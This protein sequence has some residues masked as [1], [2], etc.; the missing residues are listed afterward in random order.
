MT[1]S[2]TFSFLAEKTDEGER[3]DVVISS[4]VEDCSRNY[5]AVLVRDGMVTVCERSKKPG[6]RVRMGDEISG[7]LP[8]PV[9]VSLKPELIHIDI[10]YEDDH[11]IVLNKQAGLVVHPAPGHYSGTLVN[12]LLY[13][14]PGIGPLNGELRP[15]II[16]RLDK[17][18]SGTMVVAKNT[19]SHL[20][21]S[22]QFKTRKINKIYIALVN[23]KME[24]ATG[25]IKLPI[26]RHPVNRKKMSV[27]SRKSRSAVTL[28]KL[29]KDF[30]WASYLELQLKTGRTHQIR[31]H[32]T[33]VRHPIVGDPV[34]GGQKP[35]KNVPKSVAAIL[36]SAPRQ[37]L[38]ALCLEFSHPVTKK[39]MTF[40]SPVPPDM[41]ELLD[42]LEEVSFTP[43]LRSGIQDS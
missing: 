5:A 8:S 28:W 1:E 21:L 6:Y 27:N 20:H 7:N 38:H 43:L 39:D 26:G 25:E 42:K 18:T 29:K 19:K 13:H 30:T 37:M 2:K 34:Y 15:G 11:I 22:D 41:Q 40:S 24:T 23:G 33:A 10:H 12:A 9:M 35:A 3:L 4:H 36:K 31:V 32:C 14:C 16:H 17:D